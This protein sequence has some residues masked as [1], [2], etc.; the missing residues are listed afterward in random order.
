MGRNKYMISVHTHVVFHLLF[1]DMET[2]RVK[3][4]PQAEIGIFT[5]MRRPGRQW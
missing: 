1:V 5:G 2:E 4:G 3:T